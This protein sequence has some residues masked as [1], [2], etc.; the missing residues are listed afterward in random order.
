MG[1][2]DILTGKSDPYVKVEIIGVKD[3]LKS[4][5]VKRKVL[6]CSWDEEFELL[7]YTPGAKLRI[8]V[9]DADFGKEDDVLGKFELESTAFDKEPI[10]TEIELPQSG[11]KPGDPAYMK[12]KVALLGKPTPPPPPKT[13][14]RAYVSSRKQKSG[15]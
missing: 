6:E 2:A 1:P 10:D 14:N 15:G 8:V 5:S 13:G 9:G 7:G 12:L 11:K 4:T 3:S